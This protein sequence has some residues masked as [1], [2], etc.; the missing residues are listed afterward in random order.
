MEMEM[1]MEMEMATTSTTSTATTT[2][3]MGGDVNYTGI[4]VF[5]LVFETPMDEVL[6]KPKPKAADLAAVRRTRSGR[7]FF[8]AEGVGGDVHAFWINR[9]LAA[10]GVKRPERLSFRKREKKLAAL[11][12]EVGEW[13]D[14]EH[15]GTYIALFTH[16]YTFHDPKPWDWRTCQ[17]AE[18]RFVRSSKAKA[19]L[20][21][22]CSLFGVRYT[23]PKWSFV[24]Y[25]W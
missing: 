3:T 20:V 9:W 1:E 18:A 7:V 16:S 11:G 14:A 25:R 10:N 22:F 13:G 2:M 17:A 4:L 12:I 5:G 8:G 6:G 15:P 21:E 24:G 23:D 19:R